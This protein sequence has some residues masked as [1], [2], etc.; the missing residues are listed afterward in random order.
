MHGKELT[1]VAKNFID[2]GAFHGDLLKFAEDPLTPTLSLKGEGENSSLSRW[3][4][5]RVR[6]SGRINLT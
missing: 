5:G 2:I 4:R 3:E 6:A 1:G